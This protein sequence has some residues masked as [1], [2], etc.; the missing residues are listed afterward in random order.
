MKERRRLKR[1]KENKQHNW[2]NAKKRDGERQKTDREKHLAEMKSRGR[3]HVEI[4]IGMMDVME[5][6]EEGNHV[7]GPVPP[8][9]G[10]IH[11]QKCGDAS[12]PSGHHQPVQQANV[13]ILRPDRDRHWHRQCGQTHDG[14]ARQR[15]NEIARQASQRAEVLAAQRK[16]RLQPKQRHKYANQQWLADMIDQSSLWHGL[17]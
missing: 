4:E 5:S 9:I 12:D 2:S 11:E 14:E 17:V 15:E 3:A 13:P 1:N 7:I 8:P 16:A 10:I 6:P